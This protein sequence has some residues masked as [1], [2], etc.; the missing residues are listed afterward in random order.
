MAKILL[1]DDDTELLGLL[2]RWL[3]QESH[4][5]EA[6]TCGGDGLQLLSAYKFDIVILDW[7]MPD[8]SGLDVLKQFRKMGGTTPV[9]FLTGQQDTPSKKAGLDSGADDYLS[10]PFDPEELSARIRAILRRPAGLVPTTIAVGEVIL[11]LENKCVSLK[12]VPVQLGRREYAVLEFLMRHPNRAFS[13][14]ELLEHVWQ[15]DTDTNEDAVR[16]CI[17]KLRSKLS[18]GKGACIVITLPGAGYTISADG[19]G[20]R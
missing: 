8:L 5:V 1:V 6:A 7:A 10:K 18:G 19:H 20:E 17:K 3:K 2:Q 11:E 4:V 14:K 9:L 16:A 12:G 13:A 15:S